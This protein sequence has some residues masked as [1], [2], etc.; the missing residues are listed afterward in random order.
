MI[1]EFCP[2][3]ERKEKGNLESFDNI[4]G[5]LFGVGI[6]RYMNE[7]SGSIKQTF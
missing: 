7:F 4:F 6:Q 2:K 5:G 1:W 3:Y